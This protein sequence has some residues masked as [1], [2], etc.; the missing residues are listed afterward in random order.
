MYA[1]LDIDTTVTGD[2]VVTAGDLAVSTASISMLRAITF[3]LLTE[4]SGYKPARDFGANPTNYLGRPNNSN[5]RS[6]IKL[7]IQYG[8]RD[9]GIL[10]GPEYSIRVVPV[11]LHEV[12]IIIRIDEIL[13]EAHAE[14][15]PEEMILAYKYDFNNGTL[16]AVA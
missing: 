16:E 4:P 7:Q 11:S 10:D 6:M 12:G 1:D 3:C 13:I 5:I 14:V 15:V 2:L 8:L 9:Q